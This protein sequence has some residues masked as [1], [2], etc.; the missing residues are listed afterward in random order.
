MLL[1]N[2][3]AVDVLLTAE[4]AR[5]A[6]EDALRAHA[7]GRAGLSDPRSL[8]MRPIGRDVFYQ[9]KGAYL[10]DQEVAAYRF[11]GFTGGE[12]DD[13]GRRILLMDLT[14]G[15]I[16]A[17]LAEQRLYQQRVAAEL[18]LMIDLLRPHGA[19]RLAVVGTGRLARATTVALQ[20]LSP[21]DDVRVTSRSPVR[22]QEFAHAVAAEGIVGVRTVDSTEAACHDADVI[23]ALTTADRP[24][25]DSAWCRPGTLVVPAGE[26]QELA[27]GVL[28]RADRLY[29]DDWEQCLQIG[30][31]VSPAADGRID[32]DRLS[33]TLAELVAAGRQVPTGPEELV[34]A[35]A[36]GLTVLDVALADAIFRRAVAAGVGTDIPDL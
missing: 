19:T 23:L 29:V 33:G 1:L 34:V 5:D 4:L 7:V 12:V 14:T 6:V 27:D 32:R 9:L 35:I 26:P 36:Q 13:E 16:L 22:R 20:T 3:A 11:A 18:A 28:E 10:L 8:R 30:D 21:F 17:I 15:R 24:V 25:I 31:L 2:D